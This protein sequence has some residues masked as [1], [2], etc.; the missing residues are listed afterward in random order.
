MV[1]LVAT[2]MKTAGAE[3]S[4]TMTGSLLGK[5][6]VD[7]VVTPGRRPRSG[8]CVLWRCR[9]VSY[10]RRV[11]SFVSFFCTDCMVFGP[12]FPYKR[13]TLSIYSDSGYDHFEVN[14]TV[15]LRNAKVDLVVTP[16]RRPRS[17][18]CVLW[19]LST[20]VVWAA[21]RFAS[22][23]LLYRLYGFWT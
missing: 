14:T 16:E 13:S 17:R 22:A 11:A 10:G 20:W 5:A 3:G 23:I 8:W 4:S 19:R 6:K 18:W 1:V 12:G 7:L 9:L 15:P 2:W 21:G